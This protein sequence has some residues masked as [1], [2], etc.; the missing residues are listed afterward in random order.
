MTHSPVE[1]TAENFRELR[2]SRGLKQDDIAE[3]L[4]LKKHNISNIER[5]ERALSTAEKAILEWYFFGIIPHKIQTIADPNAILEFEPAEWRIIGIIARRNGM[6][7]NQWIVT[8]FREHLAMLETLATPRP[9]LK[10][11]EDKPDYHVKNGN[12]NGTEPE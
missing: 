5:G 3:V 12:G 7:E 10:V 11:A 8:R 2:K 9:V 1:I 6:T 4:G